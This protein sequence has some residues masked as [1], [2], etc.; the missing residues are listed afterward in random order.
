LKTQKGRP[1]D[2]ISKSLPGGPTAWE[3]RLASGILTWVAANPAIKDHSTFIQLTKGVN[4][5]KDIACPPIP[6]VEEVK[7]SIDHAGCIPRLDTTNV[8]P[9]NTEKCLYC[10]PELVSGSDNL[11][12]LLDTEINPA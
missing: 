5:I 11:L 6:E 4:T 10:H 7:D 1:L 8:F 12:K 9:L 2:D 3:A